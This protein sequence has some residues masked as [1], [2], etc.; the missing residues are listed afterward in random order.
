[1]TF[2][3]I[4]GNALEV[5]SQIE[6]SSVQCLISSPPYYRMRQYGVDYIWDGDKNCEHEWIDLGAKRVPAKRDHSPD[7]GFG[8]TRN[9][10]TY[11]AETS[12]VIS[13][14]NVCSKCGA[15]RGE[16]GWEKSPE[17]YVRHL[18]DIFE[19]IKPSLT[20]TA[21]V[22]VNLGDTFA[23]SQKGLWK[24]N[25]TFV[26]GGKQA[27]NKG[28][29]GITPVDIKQY[30]Y[31]NKDLLM[32][33]HLFAQEMRKRGW[34]LRA[35]IPW[36]CPNKMPGP[37][38]D[39]PIIGHEWFLMFTKSAKCS[40]NADKVLVKYSKTLNGWGGYDLIANG[41]S[42]WSEET[43]QPAYR[44]RDLRPNK[45][46]RN[47]RTSDWFM[48]SLGGTIG[49]YKDY[50]RYLEGV[51]SGSEELLVDETGDPL[52]LIVNNHPSSIKHFAMYNEHL[53]RPL[54]ESSTEEGDTVMD[55]F[56]GT[57]T[58][59]RCAISMNR[60]YIGIEAKE[61]YS[62]ISRNLLA[63]S[64]RQYNVPKQIPLF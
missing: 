61:E 53:I 55:I 21:V 5:S 15:W 39:R 7:G 13:N 43:G 52:A 20:D 46:G 42:E 41:V 25:G 35:E 11:R 19:S 38:K 62:E 63:E 17:E 60:N 31:K 56:S 32:I 48:E 34:W 23:G 51:K 12:Q 59:G 50:L 26:A 14:G 16:L 33:P 57:A 36:I 22:W 37:W 6:P 8:D 3:I 24:K 1:M 40:Y 44:D 10:E 64:E 28:S 27:T 47:R 45:A 9:I 54:I 2:K 18:A 29:I 49:F 4:T 58:T 30:G